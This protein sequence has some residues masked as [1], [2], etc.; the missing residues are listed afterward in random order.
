[1][2]LITAF[3]TDGVGALTTFE[4]GTATAGWSSANRTGN[5]KVE[6]L[7]SS[8]N[9]VVVSQLV[10][11]DASTNGQGANANGPYTLNFPI[12]TTIPY[13]AY[14]LR[15]FGA[16]CYDQKRWILEV[17]FTTVDPTNA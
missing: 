2:Q 10:T 1:M 8:G 11:W 15:G 4:Q 16:G 5:Y 12:S 14:R 6:A 13:I 7:E 9:W 3:D 17:N